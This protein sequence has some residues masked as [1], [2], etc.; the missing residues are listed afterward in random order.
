M[1]LQEED[2]RNMEQIGVIGVGRMGL[3]LSSLEAR[4]Q[5]PHSGGIREPHTRF[6]N[7]TSP[8]E[9]GV[10]ATKQ[11]HGQVFIWAINC[12]GDFVDDVSGYG[13][14]QRCVI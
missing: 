11:A 14:G 6:H 9:F 13:T 5:L 2:A 1:P 10:L 8:F 12:R 7:G 3:A 4:Y